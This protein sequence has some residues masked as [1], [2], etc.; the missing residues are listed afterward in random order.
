[1]FDSLS[2]RGE[3][4]AWVSIVKGV[5]WHNFPQVRGTFKDADNV[6]GYVIFNII[7]LFPL[8]FQ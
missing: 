7:F 6:R 1:M 3:L 8:C 2:R 5:R 4:T